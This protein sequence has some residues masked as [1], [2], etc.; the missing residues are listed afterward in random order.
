[1]EEQKP[2]QCCT[3][4]YTS[5]TT[6]VPKAV[7]LSHDNVTWTVKVIGQTLKLDGTD[8][9]VSYLP[10][11]HI[12]AYLVDIHGA[13]QLGITIH[14]VDSSQKEPR[15][16]HTLKEVEPTFLIGVPAVWERL[17]DALERDIQD[18]SRL[19][20]KFASMAMEIGAKSIAATEQN[21]KKPWNFS[22]ANRVVLKKVVKQLGLGQCK[23]CMNVGAS[24]RRDT[25]DFFSAL[26]I[27]ILDVYG[28]TETA[29]PA[30]V[31]TPWLYN[32][33][34]VGKPLNGVECVIR[35]PSAS[36]EGEI[37]LRGRNVFVGYLGDE[38]STENALSD[39]GFF[40]TGDLGRISNNGHV[41]IT[42]RIK[43]LVVMKDGH[44][45][46]PV[47]V[48]E[49]LRSSIPGV[50]QAM[51]VGDGRHSIVSI[52]SLCE[53]IDGDGNPT[54][55]LIDRAA[56][57]NPEIST[58]EQARSDPVWH[59]LISEC[60]QRANASIAEVADKYEIR[61]YVIAKRLFTYRGGELTALG[62]MRRRVIQ[63]LYE[64]ELEAIYAREEARVKGQALQ[65]ADVLHK[66]K[67]K[68]KR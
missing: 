66:R 23:F 54:G 48:E 61:H 8:R 58:V 24:L 59:D 52:L 67:Q 11:S 33:G 10:L 31:S 51:V 21:R 39:D 63:E 32:R 38:Y 4:M 29:G 36:G 56:N 3:L 37:L 26:H 42:G 30:T 14:L 20:Q 64:E 65:D 27:P 13:I 12:A 18:K 22:L 62:K 16:F 17:H 28:L 50:A 15:L 68:G 7:M 60:I 2:E 1:M 5:G 53:Q 19:G 47:P 49:A 55:V 57:V 40:Y 44:N 45:I 41:Y 9:G 6:G 25:F 34:S 43:E 46:S 35:N